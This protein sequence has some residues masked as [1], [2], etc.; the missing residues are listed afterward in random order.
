VLDG[1]ARDAAHWIERQEAKIDRF[2]AILVE[3]GFVDEGDAEPAIMIQRYVDGLAQGDESREHLRPFVT[4]F[5][6]EVESFGQDLSIV[7]NRL[8]YLELTA[9]IAHAARAQAK[10]D[11]PDEFRAAIRAIMS[12]NAWPRNFQEIARRYANIAEIEP[13]AIWTREEVLRNHIA[14]DP[15]QR[16]MDEIAIVAGALRDYFGGMPPSPS[17]LER[18]EFERYRKTISRMGGHVHLALWELRKEDAETRRRMALSEGRANSRV[19][20]PREARR[21]RRDDLPAPAVSGQDRQ[22]DEL[23]ETLSTVR[24]DQR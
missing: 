5:K 15:K 21:Q 16:R 10:T 2:D 9:D 3:Q 12:L 6:R 8:E 23:L 17:R 13:V 22:L 4:Y 14:V 7:K 19:G 24:S 20:P 1:D 18:Q 11:S